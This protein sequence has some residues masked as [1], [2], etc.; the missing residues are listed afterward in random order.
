MPRWIAYFE[1]DP[2]ARA[3]RDAYS[4]LHIAY[5]DA[6]RDRI[7]AAG[8]L[9]PAPDAWPNGGLWVIEAPTREDAMRLVEGDP[10]HRYGLRRA[11]R[12]HVWGKA[13]PDRTTLL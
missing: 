4:D 11:V 5:L 6:H 7:V 2:N 10:F 3:V 8:A 1:D 12:L 13:F 9:R